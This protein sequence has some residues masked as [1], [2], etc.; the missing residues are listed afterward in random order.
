[1]KFINCRNK[2]HP[3]H[4]LLISAIIFILLPSTL[5]SAQSYTSLNYIIYGKYPS[6]IVEKIDPKLSRIWVVRSGKRYP[7]E[8]VTLQ[9]CRVTESYIE[10][11]DPDGS[12]TG[13]IPYISH[14]NGQYYLDGKIVE[15]ATYKG[16]E[17]FH[18]DELFII[19]EKD[20]I[21]IRHTINH[22]EVSTYSFSFYNF[23]GQLLNKIDDM[24]YS[25]ERPFQLP[26]DLSFILIIDSGDKVGRLGPRVRILTPQGK[27][28]AQVNLFDLIG[29]TKTTFSANGDKI[30]ITGGGPVC[31]Q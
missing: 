31:R 30:G 17:T 8:K 5:L 26:A 28:K 23:D 6:G 10:L 20:V 29:M 12:I 7:T 19:E 27:K 16:P 13:K 15:E 24:N 18:Y 1:M 2:Y 11:L 4:I 22:Y 14:V 3:L 25:Y 9:K 21:I